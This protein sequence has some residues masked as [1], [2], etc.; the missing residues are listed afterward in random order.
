MSKLIENLRQAVVTIVSKVYPTSTDYH[1]DTLENAAAMG[2][3]N[4]IHTSSFPQ[5]I[6]GLTADE[7]AAKKSNPEAFAVLQSEL[8]ALDAWK[9]GI[10]ERGDLSSAGYARTITVYNDSAGKPDMVLASELYDIAPNVKKLAETL[11]VSNKLS[12][13][14][15]DDPQYIYFLNY[16][17]KDREKTPAAQSPTHFRGFEYA[18]ADQLQK[19]QEEVAQKTAGKGRIVGLLF[20]CEDKAKYPEY[21]DGE[22]LAKESVMRPILFGRAFKRAFNK[23]LVS[24]T[25]YVQPYLDKDDP[26]YCYHLATHFVAA[27]GVKELSA[28][29]R[30]AFLDRFYEQFTDKSVLDETHQTDPKIKEMTDNLIAAVHQEAKEG[31]KNGSFDERQ[32]ALDMSQLA[33]SLSALGRETFTV[34]N[35]KQILTSYTAENHL[36]FE[37]KDKNGT[38]AVDTWLKA[39]SHI[40]G[41]K[42][43][44]NGKPYDDYL[45]S[46][47]VD[48]ASSSKFFAGLVTLV[49]RQV[50][51]MEGEVVDKDLFLKGLKELG[52]AHLSQAK[53]RAA[54][55]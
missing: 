41:D 28:I 38:K 24:D 19:L 22:A 23:P 9:E 18:V 11:E 45:Y 26:N 33:S 16:V 49:T 17:F 52:A 51:A 13:I 54:P 21:N 48:G 12:H 35:A 53:G 7:L 29:Q 43:A 55:A 25:K 42:L 2:N 34:H 20:E 10:A 6:L 40:G 3:L 39:A 46:T 27:P 30:L 36:F 44:P 32:E 50:G 1:P 47:I 37:A 14:I 31:Q 8:E 5:Q 4:R 15:S